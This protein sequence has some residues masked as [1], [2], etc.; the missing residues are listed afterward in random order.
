[1]SASDS[2]SD[3][4]G[5][6]P[7]PEDPLPAFGLGESPSPVSTTIHRTPKPKHA[8]R[9]SSFDCLR[10]SPGLGER[11]AR[12][13]VKRVSMGDLNDPSSFKR[14]SPIFAD[15]LV[16][17]P[18]AMNGV[19]VCVGDLVGK[20][21]IEE[22]QAVA[23]AAVIPQIARAKPPRKRQSKTS[24]PRTAPK[25]STKAKKFQPPFHVEKKGK[26]G[27]TWRAI[28]AAELYDKFHEHLTFSPVSV[29]DVPAATVAG[30]ELTEDTR[31]LWAETCPV[32][33]KIVFMRSPV[34]KTFPR[35]KSSNGDG[36]GDGSD[37][38]DES[39]APPPSSSLGAAV[40]E[41]ISHLC[42]KQD[43]DSSSAP[44]VKLAS[45][46]R[47]FHGWGIKGHFAQFN[48]T[49]PLFTIVSNSPKNPP[50]R[51]YFLAGGFRDGITLVHSNKAAKTK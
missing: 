49:P 3:N 30:L 11:F 47:R 9:A 37:A 19:V 40:W 25:A 24:S 42:P 32:N 48:L 18:F 31:L 4:W 41:K 43:A 38:D 26:Y 29:R 23:A 14:S 5:N 20:E 39:G 17:D 15:S 44:E 22:G 6:N 35:T 34:F 10:L 28:E 51:V 13:S 16:H 33:G 1:M 45:F 12:L 21:N 2:D 27:G 50:D 36:D 46:F 7:M 8:S